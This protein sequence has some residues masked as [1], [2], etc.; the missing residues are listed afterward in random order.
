[1]K[2]PKG[3]FAPIRIQPMS[4]GPRGGLRKDGP[5]ITLTAIDEKAEPLTEDQWRAILLHKARGFVC[6]PEIL[7]LK[8]MR[9]PK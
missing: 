5:R 6:P 4:V 8:F 1:M 7:N 3:S 9:R 2:L